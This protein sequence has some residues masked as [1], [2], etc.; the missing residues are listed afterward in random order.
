MHPTLKR[1]FELNVDAD[2]I[3]AHAAREDWEGLEGACARRVR[4]EKEG[5]R[6]L[7]P[8]GLQPDLE[9]RLV[10]AERRLAEQDRQMG[11]LAAQLDEATKQLAAAIVPEED[12]DEDPEET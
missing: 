8:I 1:A 2:T 9:T 12:G 5:L 4:A 6:P 11:E 3:Q 7:R 10:D